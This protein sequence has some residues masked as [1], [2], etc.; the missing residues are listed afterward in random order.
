[1]LFSDSQLQSYFFPLYNIP[2]LASTLNTGAI[3]QLFKTGRIIQ[4]KWSNCNELVELRMQT[5]N[6]ECLCFCLTDVHLALNPYSI[7]T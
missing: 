3:P 7:H 5:G 4:S 6:A 1:M 2:F